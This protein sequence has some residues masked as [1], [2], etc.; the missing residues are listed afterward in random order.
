MSLRATEQPIVTSTVVG[1]CFLDMLAVFAE[2]ETYL[3]RERQKEGI[4]KAKDKGPYKGR[5]KTIGD[6]RI[7]VLKASGM[8]AA[9]IWLRH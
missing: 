1:K 4:A 6:E 9:D 8:S 7:K 3:R 5:R 2:F